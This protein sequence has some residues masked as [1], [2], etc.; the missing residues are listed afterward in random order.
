MKKNNLP[1]L[2]VGL[3]ASAGGLQALESFV[4]NLSAGSG[5]AYVII[6]HLSPDYKSLMAEILTKKTSLSVY[7]A[8]EGMIVESD[9]IYLIPPK[10]DMRIFKGKLTLS[11]YNSE[12]RVVNYPIDTFLQSLA[13]DQGRNAIGIIL[14]GTGSDG[15]R[16][17]RHIR[18]AAGLTMVQSIESAAFDGMPRSAIDAGLADLVLAPEE[19]PE[20]LLTYANHPIKTEFKN[21]TAILKSEDA[22]TQVF[23]HLRDREGVDFSQYK[24]ATILR[25]I[26][27]RIA[28]N[29]VKN[30]D[31]YI[32]YIHRHPGE[33]NLLFKELLIGVTS[34]FRDPEAYKKLAQTFV[35][36]MLAEQKGSEEELRVWCAGCS[37]GEEAYSVAITLTEA[38]KNA[39]SN[40]ELK[41]FAT[42]VDKEAIT[43][44]S[45]GHYAK[46]IVA[47]IPKEYMERYFISTDKGFQIS[48]KLRETIVFAQHNL[49]KDPPFSKKPRPEDGALKAPP[50]GA[51]PVTPKEGH[52]S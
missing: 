34:F 9:T 38:L 33:I 20:K 21:T 8:K 14:S 27:R 17:L 49:L 46:S 51:L 22:L 24:P 11:E 43:F 48:R 6:Q 44:A 1:C 7:Q 12:H 41:I 32:R 36:Q 2:V 39:G 19:M 42:D 50:E 29:Q 31:E 28:I 35:P 40:R 26:E 3:G 23:V 47:D 15:T 13:E 30:I 52:R 37:T 25:R 45:M 5:M 16:G 4:K 18:E 10:M